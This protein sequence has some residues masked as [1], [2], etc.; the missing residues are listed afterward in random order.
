MLDDQARHVAQVGVGVRIGLAQRAQVLCLAGREIERAGAAVLLPVPGFAVNLQ[1]KVESIEAEVHRPAG[2]VQQL[3]G[4]RV[5]QLGGGLGR[6]IGLHQQ[7]LAAL[8]QARCPARS[9]EP[10]AT[11]GIVHQELDHI[12]RREELI[13]YSQFAAVARRLRGLAHRPTLFPRIEVLV[14]PADGFVLAP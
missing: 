4:A 2:R 5:A 8:A 14:N 6:F 10:Q 7:V 12:A 11:Q 13:A 3:E 9:V 1:K